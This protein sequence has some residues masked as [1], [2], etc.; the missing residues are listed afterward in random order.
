MSQPGLSSSLLL[1]FSATH[2]AFPGT[3]LLHT[4]ALP[5]LFISRFFLEG[6]HF[7]QVFDFSPPFF[8]SVYKFSPEAEAGI[9][10]GSE[11]QGASSAS[12]QP[13]VTQKRQA[14]LSPL[15]SVPSVLSAPRW[16]VKWV[17][18]C[19]EAESG[20]APAADS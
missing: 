3:A 18:E 11:D 10:P 19:A 7:T 13:H 4:S 14:D 2:K 1:I 6:P 17:S 9:P 20:F 5:T 8:S 16:T 12:S 15:L